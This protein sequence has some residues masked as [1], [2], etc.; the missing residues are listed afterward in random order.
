[1]QRSHT[2]YLPRTWHAVATPMRGFTA[3]ELM[4]VVAIMAV[5]AALAAPSFTPLME[6]WRVRQATEALQSTIFYARSEAIKRGGNVAIQKLP[7]VPAS[8]SLAG[9]NEEWGCGWFIF[10]D[11]NSD[12]K[13]QATETRIRTI[14]TPANTNVIHHTHAIRPIWGELVA[15]AMRARERAIP[16]RCPIMSSATVSGNDIIVD[17]DSLLPLMIDRTFCKVRPDAGFTIGEGAIAVTDVRQ[18]GQRQIT[19][20]AAS[21]PIG[22]SIE[23][24]WRRQDGGDVLDQWPICTGA[25]R[26]AWEA[27][28]AFDPGKKLVRAA[29]GYQ[30]QL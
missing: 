30:L 20:T 23:Y 8:C 2:R 16:W 11:D 6:G 10:A 22:T 17:H 4:V 29:L 27:P 9:T 1:M 18:T 13:W 26:D 14:N 15:H 19:V 28:S 24:C 12:G 21:D 7:N 5:L 25:I 3:I